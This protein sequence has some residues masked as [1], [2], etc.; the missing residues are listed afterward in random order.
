MNDYK[1]NRYK[2]DEGGGEGSGWTEGRDTV[3]EKDRGGEWN[4]ERGERE[5]DAR[6]NGTENE[7]EGGEARVDGST[8]A[9]GIR[10]GQRGWV[11]LVRVSKSECNKWHM[12]VS[13]VV[14]GN[15]A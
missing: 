14:V 8:H 10:D 7:R 3:G 11:I 6:R 1:R 15:I 2:G 9:K 13:T 5:R 12:R 4:G